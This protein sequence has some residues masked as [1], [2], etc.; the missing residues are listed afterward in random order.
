MYMYVCATTDLRWWTEPVLSC[1][2]HTTARLPCWPVTQ[3][4]L[5]WLW[6]SMAHYYW[7]W[8]W[9]W[10]STLNCCCRG[11]NDGGNNNNYFVLTEYFNLSKEWYNND[12]KNWWCIYILFVLF[13]FPPQYYENRKSGCFSFT[14]LYTEIWKFDKG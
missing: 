10:R 13:C 7:W 12:A 4:L 5:P 8:W 1:Q 11:Y 2:Q 9:W 3:L 6:P 14:S